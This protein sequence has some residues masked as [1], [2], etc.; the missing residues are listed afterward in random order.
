MLWPLS[1]VPPSIS[2][3]CT[4]S[5]DRCFRTLQNASVTSTHDNLPALISAASAVASYFS[6]ISSSLELNRPH[7]RG[8]SV[9]LS[10]DVSDSEGM[11]SE[12]RRHSKGMRDSCSACLRARIDSHVEGGIVAEWVGESDNEESK[13]RRD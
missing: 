3:A 4:S 12:G 6:V 13:G 9:T 11:R 8:T 7:F 2:N 5:V 1:S 10:A